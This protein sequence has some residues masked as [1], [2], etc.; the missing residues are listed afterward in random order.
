[1]SSTPASLAPGATSAIVGKKVSP[2]L[3]KTK[4]GVSIETLALGKDTGPT[5]LM[6]QGQGGTITLWDSWRVGGMIEKL[7]SR[8]LRVILFG[9]RDTGLSQK[10]SDKLPDP[11]AELAKMMQGQ[12]PA[13]A[14]SIDDMALD[15]VGVLDHY[16]VNRAHVFGIS[17]GATISLKLGIHHSDRIKSVVA[18]S[19]AADVNKAQQILFSNQAR[20]GVMMKC[21]V[22]PKPNTK[23][24][25]EEYLENRRPFWELVA[26]V[27]EDATARE[28]EDYERGG[29]DLDGSASERQTLAGVTEDYAK[30]SSLLPSLKVPTLVI[31]GKQDPI[32]PFEC[33]K[34]LAGLIP[35]SAFKEFDCG[36]NFGKY[37]IARE[38]S[39]AVADHVLANDE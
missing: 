1:M 39:D 29:A 23:M 25:L 5:L 24:T 38:I 18:M 21:A 4:G 13:T 36:H 6:N 3:I 34:E 33:G 2:T 31:H 10:F 17:L 26:A 15:A 7:V 8:G 30:Y 14:Y 27:P 22:L 12:V 11:A 35:G 32:I 28:Q 9:A 37:E 19:T 20:N 16:K